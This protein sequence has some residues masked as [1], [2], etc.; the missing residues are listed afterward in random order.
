MKIAGAGVAAAG[1]GGVVAATG[2]VGIAGAA[3]PAGNR[4]G[5]QPDA[6]SDSSTSGSVVAYV[7]NAESGAIAVLSEGREVS[8]VDRDLADRLTRAAR[9]TES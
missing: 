7:E 5:D 6:E 3:R 9:A 2:P 4:V 8:I 1:V